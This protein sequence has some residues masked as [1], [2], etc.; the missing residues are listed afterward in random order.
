MSMQRTRIV[1]LLAV[2]RM[3]LFHGALY[4][5][6]YYVDNSYST[7]GDGT[8]ST[9]VGSPSGSGAWNNLVDAVTGPSPGDILEIREGTGVYYIN[10]EIPNPWELNYSGTAANPIITQ[11]YANHHVYISGERDIS[12]STWTHLGNG[13]Y[14]ATGGVTG[15]TNKFP[16]TAWYDRGSGQERL[17]VIQNNRNAN[18][19]LAAGHMRYTTDNHVVTYLSDDSSSADADDYDE[20]LS[21]TTT[22]T[23]GNPYVDITITPNDDILEESAETVILTLTTGT[24]YVVGTAFNATVTITD[25]DETVATITAIRA[26]TA[27]CRADTGMFNLSRPQTSSDLTV[28]YNVTGTSNNDDYDETLSG[29]MVISDTTPSIDITITPSNDRIGEWNETMILTITT[30]TGY[31]I[32]LPSSAT[33]TATYENV[34]THP[35]TV[36]NGAGYSVGWPCSATVTINDNDAITVTITATYYNVYLLTV[37][38]GT[39]N[40]NYAES[41]VVA[42]SADAPPPNQAFD[43]WTGDTSYIDY[44]NDTDANVTMPNA[45]VS[46][47]AIYTL[48]NRT[49][50][51]QDSGSDKLVSMEAENYEEILALTSDSARTIGSGPATVTISNDDTVTITATDAIGTEAGETS[52]TLSICHSSDSIGDLTVNYNVM[53]TSNSDDYDE[54]LSGSATITSGNSYVDITITPNDDAIGKWDETVILTITTGTD[55]DDLDDEED[56]AVIVTLFSRNG[57]MVDLPN[58][59]TVTGSQRKKC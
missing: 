35:L 41:T 49:V 18:S 14:E 39:G 43:I 12:T 54:T 52:G 48:A 19:T 44:P 20:T 16:F 51:Q 28:N 13:V 53:G 46:V 25:N 17:K 56:E 23:S 59:A 36:N 32:G 10:D 2:A 40:G 38:D 55:Y 24:G 1:V 31:D 30:K 33:V 22:I 3:L 34:T 21:G 27:E 8:A 4:G 29:S 6:T 50:S 57:Y 47:T 45:D 26:S 42:I 11:N 58:R 15:T 7:N 5:A 37:T 9:D